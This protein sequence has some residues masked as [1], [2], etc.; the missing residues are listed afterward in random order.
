MID[1]ADAARLAA[2]L[3]RNDWIREI[4][5]RFEAVALP[6]AWLVAGCLAQTVW[7]VAAGLAAEGGIKDIDLVYHD[8][9]DLTEDGERAQAARLRG[10]FADIPVALDVKN[11][12]RV[13]QWYGS[14][15]GRV[16]DPYASTAAAIATYPATATA[17]GVRPAAEALGICAP[18]GLGDL[19]AGVVRPNKVLV[20]R[21][22]YEAKAARWRAAWPSLRIVGWDDGEVRARVCPAQMEAPDR[23]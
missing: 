16:I 21:E 8:P 10:I 23:L 17:L 11:Q 1:P 9:D 18:F 12:A 4:L 5:D 19:F 13:H 2:V 3:R 15:F 6:D 14:K 7:N 20:S 22:V